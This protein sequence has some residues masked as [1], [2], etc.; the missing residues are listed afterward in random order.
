MAVSV[1]HQ[2]EQNMF[3]A[4]LDG[5]DAGRLVYTPHKTRPE[6]VVYST[7]VSPVF[8]GRGVGSALTL[9]AVEA[10][11][12]QQIKIVP[13]CWFVAGWLD[14]HPEFADVRK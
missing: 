12:A 1:E 11:Q 10:A 13:T 6:W 14:R 9:T 7:S 5:Q 4:R 3:T 2:A 8:E